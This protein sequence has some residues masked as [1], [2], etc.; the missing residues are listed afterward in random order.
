MVSTCVD[1]IPLVRD[2][3]VSHSEHFKVFLLD[4]MFANRI[5]RYTLTF[6]ICTKGFRA[7]VNITIKL[8]TNIVLC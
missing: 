4:D 2:C 5:T 1:I 7:L 8:Q 3:S 6:K